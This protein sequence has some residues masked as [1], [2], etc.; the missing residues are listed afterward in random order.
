[1][2]MRIPLLL[3]STAI[4]LAACSPKSTGPVAGRVEV[5]ATHPHDPRAYTQ[6]L[7]VDGDRLYEST[8]LYGESTFREV[9]LATGKIL[10]KIDLPAKVFGEGSTRLGENFW[11]ITWRE[12]SAYRI[13]PV[14]LA[15]V[16]TNTFDG[17]GWGLGSDGRHLVMSD[18][19]STLTWID[20][21]SFTPVKKVGVTENGQ[22][23]INLN[24][25]EFMDNAILANVYMQDRIVRINPRNGHVM[26][27]Y[28][29]QGLRALLPGP[30]Q[31]EALNGIAWRTKTGTLLVTGKNWPLLFELRLLD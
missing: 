19:T 26:A 2:M 3:I 14:S 30:H 11:M 15:I 5:V 25:L 18:G 8:G 22:P 29:L 23:V 10:R 24:E 4:A 17:E 28:D 7:F 6:G 21:A 16:S 27:S 1:M 13:D 9:E 12:R 31:A 20:P